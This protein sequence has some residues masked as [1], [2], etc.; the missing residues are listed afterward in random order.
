MLTLLFVLMPLVPLGYAFLETRSF[1]ETETREQLV[2]KGRFVLEASAGISEPMLSRR[3]L[4]R[5]ELFEV[6][7]RIDVLREVET[8]L[9][10]YR[11]QSDAGL[12]RFEL[13][14]STPG[15]EV[16]ASS[17]LDALLE[18][19][20]SVAQQ[21]AD[22]SVGD[23]TER[24]G[25][26]GVEIV[27]LVVEGRSE[28]TLS[29]ERLDR[30]FKLLYEE[31]NERLL[32]VSRSLQQVLEFPTRRNGGAQE[33]FLAQPVLSFARSRGV[34]VVGVILLRTPEAAVNH[35][36]DPFFR[37]LG[38]ALLLAFLLFVFGVVVTR[39]KHGKSDRV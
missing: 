5:T 36:R 16:P 19:V 38:G 7:R 37:R 30:E 12:P 17:V 28:E 8:V 22:D 32:E 3:T 9:L 10:F 29:L 31:G 25:E 24:L 20:V 35:A 39:G 6:G 15:T 13:V 23:I 11:S 1:I 27:N 26:L 21:K 18:P 34:E 2:E 4:S 33:P 14:Y